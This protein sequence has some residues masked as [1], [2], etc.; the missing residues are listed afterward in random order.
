M[1]KV[2]ILVALMSSITLA[3][4]SQT[5][6]FGPKFK[7]KETWKKKGEVTAWTV[8]KKF[9]KG[10]EFKNLPTHEIRS[11]EITVQPRVRV[12]PKKYIFGPRAKNR[13]PWG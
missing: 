9:P 12:K 13:K 7:N 2:V 6:E 3:S 4:W 11:T 8:Q 1:G 5:N 10:P